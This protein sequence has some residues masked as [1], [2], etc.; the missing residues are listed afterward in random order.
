MQLRIP[1]PMNGWRQFAGEVGIIVVGVLIAL[2]AQEVVEDMHWRDQVAEARHSLDAQ[3]VESKF[4]SLE[5]IAASDCIS[6]KLDFLDGIIASD[7]PTAKLKDIEIVG[8][9]LWSTSAWD[10][11]IS[12]GAVAHMAP[13]TRNIY[14]GLFSFTA[15]MREIHL[16]AYEAS[17]DLKTLE[18]HPALTDVSRDRLAQNVAR[19]RAI[20]AM[21]KLGS[22][23]WL[24]GAEP[25]GLVLDGVDSDLAEARRCVLP[26]GSTAPAGAVAT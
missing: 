16:K 9:R 19:L 14:A 20:N 22:Q 8:L 24:A 6:R 21:L 7:R 18:R 10:A 25:L 2:G 15:A 26:D 23:Q 13:E 1:Q 5:R 4:A 17:T 11:A 12:S 3:L